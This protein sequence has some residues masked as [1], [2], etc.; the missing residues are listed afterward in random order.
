MA[1]VAPTA[2]AEHPAASITRH[3]TNSRNVGAL[4][5]AVPGA[6]IAGNG[7]L[8]LVLG[9]AAAGPGLTLA[10]GKNDFWGWP[11]EHVIFGGSFN[12]FSPGW[13]TLVVSPPGGRTT[14]WNA[15]ATGSVNSTQRLLDGRLTL[16]AAD[17]SPGGYG[18][19]SEAVV[20]RH[21]GTQRNTILLNFTVVCPG[22][23]TTASV[24]ANLST[25]NE[26]VLPVA[27]QL[28]GSS[29]SGS[30]VDAFPVLQLRKKNQPTPWHSTLLTPCADNLILEDGLRSFTVDSRTSQLHVVGNATAA[31]NALPRLCLAT[32]P[33]DQRV[34]TVP[35]AVN[36]TASL[37][38]TGDDPPP[39]ASAWFWRA[40]SGRVTSAD[41]TRCMA[42]E[43]SNSSRCTPCPWGRNGGCP[44]QPPPRTQC[45]WQQYEIT[46]RPC[47]TADRFP[48]SSLLWRFEPSAAAAS[49]PVAG[50]GAA[51]GMLQAVLPAPPLSVHGE[52]L[53]NFTRFC[54]T[55]AVP[56]VSNNLAMIVRFAEPPVVEATAEG[57][58][59]EAP[60]PPWTGTSSRGAESAAGFVSVNLTLSCGVQ[61][62]VAIGVATERDASHAGAADE[63][64]LAQQYATV[65]SADQPALMAEH[66]RGWA[67]WWNRSSIEFAHDETAPP[68]FATVYEWYYCS[69]Y[70]LGSSTRVGAVPP[71]I[72]GPWSVVDTPKYADQMTL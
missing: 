15:S 71:S 4:G 20:L 17:L 25:D 9:S 67:E 12:H 24:A 50:T 39:P 38:F 47:A 48:N 19:R 61:Y 43:D 53:P 5:N 30:D 36:R 1:A 63:L 41:G 16:D 68:E 10:M 26:W 7:D 72:W 27:A 6:L 34:I 3:I 59:T 11:G 45:R 54:L 40:D 13:L 57:Y 31:G 18:I 37:A 32:R 62:S 70:I 56:T 23:Q 44:N 66:R 65:G 55:A 64:A 28:A 69:L 8:G 33:H 58:R 42:I 29:G 2:C 46:A 35:C 21:D 22:G 51:A 14:P 49:G 60:L 52:K